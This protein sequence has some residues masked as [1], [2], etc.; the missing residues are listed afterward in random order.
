MFVIMDSSFILECGATF[1]NIKAGTLMDKWFGEADK[2]VGALF[3]YDLSIFCIMFDLFGI[4][5]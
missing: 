3:R 1:I 4:V 5:A 2:L